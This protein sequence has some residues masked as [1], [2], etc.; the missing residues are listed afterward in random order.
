MLMTKR[1]ALICVLVL[2]F[3]RPVTAG[4]PDGVTVKTD[5]AYGPD[6]AQ[7]MDVYLP[8]APQQAPILLMVHGGAWRFGDKTNKR[9][10]DNK[11]A[12]W[13]PQGVIFVS[14]NYRMIPDAAPVVQ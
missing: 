14:V 4:I 12:H 6:P 9:V 2:L 3:A 8:P 13:V 7:R 11:V 1:L 5:I 10:V